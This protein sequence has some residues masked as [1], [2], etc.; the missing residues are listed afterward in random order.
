[1]KKSNCLVGLIGA[2]IALTLINCQKTENPL[3]A[4]FRDKDLSTI[5]G[6]YNQAKPVVHYFKIS[7]GE[8]ECYLIVDDVIQDIGDALDNNNLPPEF[9]LISGPI[10]IDYEVSHAEG[11]NYVQVQTW[12]DIIINGYRWP[13]G[14]LE[15]GGVIFRQSEVD[16][17]DYNGQQA[18][19]TFPW[20]GTIT[21]DGW[22]EDVY[23]EFGQYQIFDQL[24][25]REL[26][27]KLGGK[28]D[29]YG[30][31]FQAGS[32]GRF[33]QETFL[34]TET[35][36]IK[37][38]EASGV[39]L[40]VKSVVDNVANKRAYAEIE[41]ITMIDQVEV[42]VEDAWVFGYWRGGGGEQYYHKG[43]TNN[44]GIAIIQGPRVNPTSDVYF[45]V[46]SVEKALHPYNPW[47]HTTW[48]WMDDDIWDEGEEPHSE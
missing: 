37:A 43:E 22:D 31:Y 44:D 27:Q 18:T 42:P 34:V 17:E 47:L 16:F 33:P 26:D 11:I 38:P 1:M 10:E 14:L 46:R 20:D 28:S 3:E 45:T 8:L 25:T 36:R 48:T 41:V 39:Q 9:D 4:Q 29:Y 30:F 5:Q 15:N 2:I 23:R 40:Q 24:A 19:G 6:K 21:P 12:C 32:L 7:Q 13:D 35:V